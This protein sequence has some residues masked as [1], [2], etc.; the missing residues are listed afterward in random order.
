MQIYGKS[1]SGAK[2]WDYISKDH[3]WKGAEC[4]MPGGV[5]V[6]YVPDDWDKTLYTCVGC[7]GRGGGHGHDFV[8]AEEKYGGFSEVSGVCDSL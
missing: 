4:N 2:M 7:R 1:R 3:E 6:I 5:C 8:F